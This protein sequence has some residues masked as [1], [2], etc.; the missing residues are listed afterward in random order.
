MQQ[1]AVYVEREGHPV[2]CDQEKDTGNEAKDSSVDRADDTCARNLLREYDE[3][4]ELEE[5]DS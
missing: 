4:A 2:G 5:E 3:H 1:E